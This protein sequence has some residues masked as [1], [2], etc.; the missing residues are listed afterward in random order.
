MVPWG[1]GFI[2]GPSLASRCTTRMTHSEKLYDLSAEQLSL[3]FSR[4]ELSPVDVAQSCLGRI[5]AWEPSI[6]AM[7]LIKREQAMEQA[8]AS[9]ARWLKGT[10][11][12]VLDGVPIT[13]KENIYT[14]GDPAPIG[15][16]LMDMTP[17][18]A[19]APVAAR[20]REAG[21]VILGKTTMP[22]FGMLSSGMSSF[23]GITRNP[24]Q[25]D[26]NTSGSSSGTKPLRW[27]PATDQCMS[28]PTSGGRSDCLPRIAGIFAL[29]PSQG[30]VPVNPPYM[31]RIAGP[32]T[33]SVMDAALLMEVIS[34]PDNRDFMNLPYQKEAYGARLK[35][36]SVKGKRIGLMPDVAAHG[37]IGLKPDPQILAAVHAAARG[38]R[39]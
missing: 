26:R 16:H 25:L 15:T 36:F 18:A 8:K 21:M 37:A 33:R 28:A 4:K 29:K 10:P 22:D 14:R 27:R 7:Y 6:N 39:S 30:R 35:Q 5:D 32:M 9:E 13:L 19:D 3:A 20:V 17:K 34:R 12:D 1:R 11:L 2:I 38:A 24:W 23:H 31:G